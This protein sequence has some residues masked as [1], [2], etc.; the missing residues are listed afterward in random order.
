MEWKCKWKNLYETVKFEGTLKNGKKNGFGK[1]FINIECV[2]EGEFLDDKRWNG[3]GGEKNSYNLSS[4][5]VTY[6]N[7]IKKIS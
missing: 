1:E 4:Q 7:G 6:E 2:F 3:K 5:L